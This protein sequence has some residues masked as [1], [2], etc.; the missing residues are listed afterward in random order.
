[1]EDDGEDDMVDEEDGH[2]HDVVDD[3]DDMVA[4]LEVTTTEEKFN[5]QWHPHLIMILF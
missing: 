4:H 3:G 5:W 2:H 1:M